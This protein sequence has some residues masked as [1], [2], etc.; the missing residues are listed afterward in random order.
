[1][2]DL[3][4]GREVLSRIAGEANAGTAMI[5]RHA[6]ASKARALDPFTLKV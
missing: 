1:M 6:A 5:N 3:T 2:E 4:L